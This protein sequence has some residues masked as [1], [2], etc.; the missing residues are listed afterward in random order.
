M[1]DQMSERGA[2]FVKPDMLAR[3]DADQN[4]VQEADWR[5]Y[6]HKLIGDAQ[7]ATGGM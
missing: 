1:R 3:F 5:E 2:A 6:L 4:A 7:R